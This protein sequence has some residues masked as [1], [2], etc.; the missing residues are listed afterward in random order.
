MKW[1]WL[2]VTAPQHLSHR[3]NN[4][5]PSTPYHQENE[6]DIHQLSKPGEHLHQLLNSR[7]L[8]LANANLNSAFNQKETTSL[9]CF[10]PASQSPKHHEDAN[11]I[12]IHDKHQQQLLHQEG[13]GCYPHL[14]PLYTRVL[15]KHR[16]EHQPEVYS[17]GV[18]K[19]CMYNRERPIQCLASR[20]KMVLV[21]EGYRWRV[22]FL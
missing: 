6:H 12:C 9:T 14:K 7:D 1:R 19:I 5:I 3:H 20:I 18:N 16:D 15:L 10:N 2:H 21:G 8:N 11:H 4:H 22:Q 13:L 17:G